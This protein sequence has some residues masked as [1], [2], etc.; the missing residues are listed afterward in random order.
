MSLDKFLEYLG[1]VSDSQKIW[2]KGY[3]LTK[4]HFSPNLA[5]IRQ[6]P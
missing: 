2:A 4:L 5:D 6:E 3:C 1:S